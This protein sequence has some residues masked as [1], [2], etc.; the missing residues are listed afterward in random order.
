MIPSIPGRNQPEIDCMF[1]PATH[2]DS[3]DL[4]PS[5]SDLENAEKKYLQKSTIIMANPNAMIYQW[6]VTSSNAYWL[7]FF[8][9]RDSNVII[10]NYRGYG[11]S[12]QSIFSPNLTPNE[13]QVDSERVLQ[14]L[15]NRIRVRG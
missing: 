7:D 10:W 15:I 5:D 3:I 2:G 9:R 6:M 12:Q 4:D 13:Q 14:F 8:L 1:F 11:Y